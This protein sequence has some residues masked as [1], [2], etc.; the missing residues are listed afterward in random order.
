MTTQTIET[1]TVTEQNAM[2]YTVKVEGK[3]AKTFRGES[4]WSDAQRFAN[5]ALLAVRGTP[6]GESFIL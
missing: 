1:V 4:A 2:L 5:D 6:F 3:R